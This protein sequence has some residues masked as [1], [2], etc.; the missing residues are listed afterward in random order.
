[1]DDLNEQADYLYSWMEVCINLALVLSQEA[2]QENYLAEIIVL[3]A[4]FKINTDDASKY[5][6]ESVE[7]AKTIKSEPIRSSAIDTI[8]KF[9]DS[10]SRENSDSSPKEEIAFYR[11]RAK[12]LGMNVD[13]PEDRMGRIIKQGLKDYNPERVIKDCKHLLVFPSRAQG[14]PARMVGLRTA[15]MKWIYCLKKGHA[16]GGW[17]LDDIYISPIEQCGFKAQ[18]CDGCSSKEPR[19]DTW[20]WSSK[21]QNDELKKHKE[22]IVKI[23][24]L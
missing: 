11:D 5:L 8:A 6:D 1:M 13:D 22:I 17:S 23:D 20:K 10:L 24:S 3:N 14:I 18:Y 21:W 4:S 9:R 12:A 15:A 2:E 19:E 7:L 16:V